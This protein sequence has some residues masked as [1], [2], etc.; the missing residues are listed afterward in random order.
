MVSI[1]RGP[2]LPL[3]WLHF[4]AERSAPSATLTNPQRRAEWDELMTDLK[5]TARRIR[6]ML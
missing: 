4:D 1:S 6:R 3:V 2:P 5:G